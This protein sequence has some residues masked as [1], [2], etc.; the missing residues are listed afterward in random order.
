MRKLRS[1]LSLALIA[2]LTFSNISPVQANPSLHIGVAYDTGGLGDH[3]FNDAVNAGL[4]LAK[5]RIKFAIDSTVTIGTENDRQLRILSLIKK[6]C[7]VVVVVGS[8]YASAL[9]VVATQFPDQQFAIINDESIGLRN[10]TSLVF[11]ENQGGYLAGAT[12]ALLSKSSKIGIITNIAQNKGFEKGFASG[13][14]TVKSTIVI[15]SKYANDSVA[16]VAKLMIAQGADVIFS[17]N[18]GSDVELLNV[19]AAA[20]KIG[21]SVGVIGLEPEQYATLS[22][23]T[24]K[25]LV[26]SVVKRID[27]ALVDLVS[28]VSL[29]NTLSDILNPEVGSSGRR[30]GIFDKGVEISLWSPDLAKVA[31]QINLLAKKAAKLST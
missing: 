27:I 17:T 25:Y 13:A 14:T 8:Q 5:K 28:E 7:D 19:V 29:G 6:K 24:K 1:V 31:K 3:S 20:N 2:V 9:K 12:A 21:K 26:A 11:A 23:S 18:P 15:D 30:Y 10:V 4:I 22:A 16:S